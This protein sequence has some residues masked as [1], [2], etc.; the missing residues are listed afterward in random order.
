MI[1]S[2]S[3]TVRNVKQVRLREAC[4]GPVDESTVFWVVIGVHDLQFVVSYYRSDSS[5]LLVVWYYRLALS[6]LLS[7]LAAQVSRL[8]LRSAVLS[9]SYYSAVADLFSR[10]S[11]V[12]GDAT[13]DAPMNVGDLSSPPASGVESSELVEKQAPD[14]VAGES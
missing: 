11:C 3:R 6:F 4:G 2:V 1:R 14:P 5:S 8:Q 7:C 9:R 10:V 12:T 13:G